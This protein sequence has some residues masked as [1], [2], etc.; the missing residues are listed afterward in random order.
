V[1]AS[2]WLSVANA[3]I[4]FVLTGITAWYAWSTARMLRQL[5]NQTEAT[6][7]QAD[8]AERTLQHLL[9][10]TE[11]QRGVAQTVVQTTIET[12]LTN[13]A[14]WRGQ[15]LV[16]L[17]AM[18]LVPQVS[19]VPESGVR[20]IEHARVVAPAA[21]IP[22]S[23]A[24]A[25]LDQCNSEFPVLDS[26]GGRSTGDIEQQNQRIQALFSDTT[27]QLLLAQRACQ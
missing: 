19:L 4:V 27:E 5:K 25:L 10:V 3:T 2:E 21:A 20:A 26:L 14:Y 13:I 18:H 24:L 22:L 6:L 11:E 17:A 15:N 9:Q 8:T 23:R 16:N 12:A 1:S 7:K